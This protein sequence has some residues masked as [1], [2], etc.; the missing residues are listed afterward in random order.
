MK[1]STHFFFNR[2]SSRRLT[3]LLFVFILTVSCEQNEASFE[4]P[5]TTDLRWFKGNTHTH[6]DKSDGDSS[7]EVVAKWYKNNGYQFLVLSDHNVLTSTEKHSNLQD[8][9]FL[10]IP[11]EEITTSY[12]KEACAC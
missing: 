1:I 3:T 4:V 12:E 11:G 10:L 5:D 7:P 6:T 2:K 9:T 8:S